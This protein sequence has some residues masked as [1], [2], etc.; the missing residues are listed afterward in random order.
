LLERH[1]CGADS[2]RAVIAILAT[3]ELAEVDLPLALRTLRAALEAW[4]VECLDDLD[5]FATRLAAV[6]RYFRLQESVH[7]GGKEP[8]RLQ[9]LTMYL[10]PALFTDSQFEVF[11]ALK[12]TLAR[13]CASPTCTKVL[14]D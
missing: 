2:A 10:V 11:R 9:D 12:V 6:E 5:T 8:R 13:L 3:F 7:W 1:A 4:L 14:V